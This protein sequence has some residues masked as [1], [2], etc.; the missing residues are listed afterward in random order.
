MVVV[1]NR[2]LRGR[3]VPSLLLPLTSSD[4][5]GDLTVVGDTVTDGGIVE[6]M[7]D[8]LLEKV[9]GA[10]DDDS[11]CPNGRPGKEGPGTCLRCGESFSAVDGRGSMVGLLLGW[12]VGTRYD[13][14]LKGECWL[15][16]VSGVWESDIPDEFW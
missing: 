4:R 1:F 8:G 9:T 14:Q 3:Q 5:E 2:L 7:D 10:T 11:T 12:L 6:E 15:D 13:G 16:P